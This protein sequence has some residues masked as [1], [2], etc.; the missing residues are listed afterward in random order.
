MSDLLKH[1]WDFVTSRNVAVVLL[2]IVTA[3]L[4]VGAVLPNPAFLSPEQQL[5]M[6]L[7]HPVLKW[8]GERY[9]SQTLAGGN[10][11]GFI[12]I[13]LI[14]S[15][16]LCSIDRLV[17]KKRAKAGAIFT[18]PFSTEQQGVK[19]YYEKIGAAELED[20][21]RVWFKK[22]KWAIAVQENSSGKMIVGSRGSAGFRGSIFF[23]FILITA[24]MGLVIYY[25]GAY[26][27][28]L[29]FTEG[30]SY[31]LHKDNI[32]RILKEPAWG[33]NLPDA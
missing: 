31:R 27:A 24:L 28:T 1:I 23:H 4:A 22:Q 25:F 20:I 10:I 15:T 33:L 13:F 7:K 11:F 32:V 29:G 2:I 6:H 5:E 30:Q 18:F 19:V 17:K 12:G 16:A 8:L 9:N 14:F 26:R 21:S 3:M